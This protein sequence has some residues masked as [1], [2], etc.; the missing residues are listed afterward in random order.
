M[1]SGWVRVTFSACFLHLHPTGPWPQV[2]DPLL[3]PL[4]NFFAFLYSGW[5][6]GRW[7]GGGKH[8]SRMEPGSEAC[9]FEGFQ[10]LCFLVVIRGKRL[11]LFELWFPD[12]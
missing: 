4:A 8:L 6:A 10:L 1:Y 2:L 9:A 12:V 7:E 3:D 5:G 11:G